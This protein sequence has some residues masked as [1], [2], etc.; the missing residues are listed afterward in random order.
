MIIM[1]Q[2]VM[3]E[4]KKYCEW[5]WDIARVSYNMAFRYG[6][7]S[8]M[9]RAQKMTRK[10]LKKLIMAAGESPRRAEGKLSQLQKS[11]CP[12]L[13]WWQKNM[14]AGVKRIAQR[15]GADDGCY[16]FAHPFIEDELKQV[17]AVL[18]CYPNIESARD[19][20]LL[21][22]TVIPRGG[23]AIANRMY[24]PLMLADGYLEYLEWV[25]M[26]GRDGF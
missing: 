19:I 12:Y 20:E 22:Q 25:K 7:Y 1:N 15:D 24:K 16:I 6:E 3:E 2:I 21:I 14:V 8:K 18:E 17:N 9:C 10:R 26:T 4:Y 23:G 11:G 5:R 13:Y